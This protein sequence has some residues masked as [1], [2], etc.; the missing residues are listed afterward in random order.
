MH[1]SHD[2]RVRSQEAKTESPSS[3][4]Q[5]GNLLAEEQQQPVLGCMDEQSLG[6]GKN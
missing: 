4:W 6:N 2:L 3:Q 5:N 1:I